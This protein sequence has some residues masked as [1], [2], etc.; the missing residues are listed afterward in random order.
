MWDTIVRAKR[1]SGSADE[2]TSKLIIRHRIMISQ[3][4]KHRVITLTC[5][6]PK[7]QSLEAESFVA[8]CRRRP[9]GRD[10]RG[11]SHLNGIVVAMAAVKAVE[12]VGNVLIVADAV[13]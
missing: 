12:E 5:R 8:R 9:S 3:C 6:Q 13:T 10:G 4:L 11:S 7:L 2:K 1:T